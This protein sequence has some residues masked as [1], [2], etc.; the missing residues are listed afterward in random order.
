MTAIRATMPDG[1]QRQMKS[2]FDVELQSFYEE[3][4]AQGAVMLELFEEDFFGEP[5]ETL[6]KKPKNES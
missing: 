4:T 2:I 6:I 3:V 1:T 5:Y